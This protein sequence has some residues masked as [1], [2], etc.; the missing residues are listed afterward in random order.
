MKHSNNL[1][2]GVDHGT[3]SARAA[4]ID[5]E[6]GKELALSIKE[7]PRWKRGLYCNPV[8]F[9]FR[10]HPVDH[11]EAIEYVINAVLNKVPGSKH[12]VKAIGI[13]TTASTPVAVDHEGSPLAMKSEFEDYPNAM[14]VLWKDHTS[15]QAC[16]HLNT[17]S[18]TWHTDYT[19][20]EL[21]GNYSTEHFWAKALHIFRD[22]K[23]RTAAHSF[24][25]L[26]D[27]LPG[28]LT[29]NTTPE[30][31]LR[32]MST[33]SSRGMW[34][35]AWGGYPPDTY[36]KALDPALGGLIDTFRPEPYTLDQPVGT[37][38]RVWAERLNLNDKVI[39]TVGNLDCYA[40]A[41]GAGVRD[42]AIVEIIGTSTC[43]ITVS[44][45]KEVPGVPQQ[46]YDMI[47]PGMIGYEGGQSC[48]GDLYAWFKKMLMWPLNN[49]LANTTIV[50]QD[51]KT[52]LID[53]VY[54]QMLPA[55]NSHAA[56][57]PHE[58]SH[59]I[60]TDWINGRRSPNVDYELKGTIAG[61]TLSSTAP[62]VYRSLVEATAFGAKAFTAQFQD[63]GGCLEE[64]IAVG[65][66]ASKSPYVMQ[67][68]ADVIG[69]PISVIATREA[70][71]HGA[72]ITA[73]VV[74]GVYTDIPQAQKAMKM[75]I[76]TVYKP[77]TA[78]HDY[79]AEQYEK[80]LKLE[81]VKELIL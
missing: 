27:W 26:C 69:M 33:A 66:I 52:K 48:F 75:D 23:I 34:N 54:A 5:A 59:L 20:S 45:N 9:Q 47:I 10:Q 14:F 2:I 12:H 70:C 21:C 30:T 25:E 81:G 68:L 77:N 24:V 16:D 41:I 51:T 49:I 71:A 56:A 62:L 6:T 78:H 3:D 15:Q 67:V 31:L 46:A 11:L 39:V 74:A 19:R 79:Y 64:I 42:R 61:L 40:G 7:Y 29:G 28:E 18:K 50:D 73:A 58:D 4:L 37:L 57:I 44:S 55:L 72:A 43:A 65:G 13:D 32:G 22:N 8:K 17:F 38:T 53:E 60:S 35:K 76:S 63:N 80:Y 1:V 36:F